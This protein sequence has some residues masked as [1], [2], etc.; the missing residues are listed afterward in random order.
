[1]SRETK[2]ITYKNGEKEYSCLFAQLSPSKSLKFMMFLTKVVGGS[3][4]KVIGS[5]NGGSIQDLAN[6][7]DDQIDLEKIGDAIFG[8]FDRVD[9]DEVI[10][11]LN[12]LFSSVSIEGEQLDVDH[13]I[14]QG[15]PTLIFKLAKEAMAVNYSSFLEGISSA[16]KKLS[17]KI[18]KA[19]DSKDTQKEQT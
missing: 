19:Q 18:K 6:I 4:A 1:M 11:K 8:L 5:L 9:E 7:N 17:G 2:T 14:F 13:L 10:E 15:Q 16:I 3:T 12:L